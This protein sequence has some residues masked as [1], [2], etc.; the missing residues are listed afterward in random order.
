LRSLGPCSIYSP[1]CWRTHLGRC[2]M[3]V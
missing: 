1:P 3:Y 2:Q